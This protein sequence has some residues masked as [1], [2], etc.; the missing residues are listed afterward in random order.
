MTCGTADPGN[1]GARGK[2]MG[3][4]RHVEPKRNM[5]TAAADPRPE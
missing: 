2:G 5:G 4:A 1:I 3:S